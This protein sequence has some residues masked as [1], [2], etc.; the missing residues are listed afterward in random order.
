MPDFTLELWRVMEMEK[1]NIGLDDYPIFDEDYRETLNKKITD[2]YYNREIG[3][4][5]IGRF[6]FA[7]GRRMREIMPYYND[8]YESSKLEFDPLL[9]VDLKTVNNSK[10]DSSAAVEA[11]SNT[12]STSKSGARAVTSETPQTMLG[13]Q[14]DYATSATDTNN[15]SEGSGSG[16]ESTTSEGVEQ[17]AGES[18]TT[19]YQGNPSALLTEYR[20]TLM[21]I[22]MLVIDELSDLFMGVWSSGDDYLHPEYPFTPLPAI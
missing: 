11:S 10:T 12:S 4:E 21:N 8:L 9:T 19:G 14:G 18:Q 5:T 6:T 20:R 22:D 3:H 2:H 7:L 13:G 15:A 1:G 17:A 16:S